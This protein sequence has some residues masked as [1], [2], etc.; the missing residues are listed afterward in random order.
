MIFFGEGEVRMDFVE[1]WIDGPIP[2]DRDDLEDALN[3]A[4]AGIGEVVGAGTSAHGSNLDVEVNESSNRGLV[5][6]EI[7]GVMN[8]LAVGDSVRV[9]PGDGD[10]WIRPSEWEAPNA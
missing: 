1:I 6:D 4:L 2:V 8:A 3:E 10:L 9:R 5:L 7:F